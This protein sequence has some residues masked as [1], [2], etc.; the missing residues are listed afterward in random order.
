MLSDC[1]AT[2]IDGSYEGSR[3]VERGAANPAGAGHHAARL[4]QTLPRLTSQYRPGCL[5]N[6]RL[7]TSGL[8]Q[9]V[10]WPHGGRNGGSSALPG[11]RIAV[12]PHRTSGAG[13]TPRRVGAVGQ[14]A[15]GFFLFHVS[16]NDGISSSRASLL[17]T[18]TWVIHRCQQG[19]AVSAC[20]D[21]GTRALPRPWDHLLAAVSSWGVRRDPSS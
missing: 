5:M 16:Q 9:I 15:A 8:A 12:H 21:H 2:R 3:G 4:T 19:G 7:P 6:D 14:S 1:H 17:R 13:R 10:V 18:G 11:M 20:Q